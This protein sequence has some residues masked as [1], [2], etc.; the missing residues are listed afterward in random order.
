M[1]DRPPPQ[2]YRVVERRGRLEVIDSV[3][4]ERPPSAAERM[5]SHDA[6]HGHAAMRFDRAQDLLVEAAKNAEKPTPAPT[7]PA[8]TDPVRARLEAKAGP[9]QAK[10]EARPPKAKQAR[11]EPRYTGTDM[12][13]GL[14]EAARGPGKQT[15][16]V[17]GKW[18]DS[19]GPRAVT[20]GRAGRAKLTNGALTFALFGFFIAIVIMIIQPA[21]LLIVAFALFR[22]GGTFIGPIGA[23]LIDAAI[24]AD[25]GKT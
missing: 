14:G 4:G 24:K 1:V 7:S 12:G 3:T 25:A 11:P 2:R 23:N 10:G 17:T 20:L 8:P 21:L 9:W 18:W 13:G 15:P 16:F 19:K 6:A 22:F 5:A